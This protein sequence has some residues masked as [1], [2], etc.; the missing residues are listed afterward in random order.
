[1][2]ADQLLVA[3]QLATSRSQAQRLIANGLQWLKGAEWKTVTKNGDEIPPDAQVRLLDDAEARYVS[4]GGLKLEAALKQVGL[5]VTG[6]VCLDVGQSTGG[7]T[8][9]LLQQGAAM[10][11]GVDQRTQLSTQIAS[12]QTQ[13]QSAPQIKYVAVLADG[14]ADPSMLVTFDATNNKLLLQRVGGYQE[15]SDKS[16][17][18]WALPPSGGPR[19]LGVLG[20]DKLLRL[21]AGEGDVHA[22]P[23]LAITLEP[24]GGVPVGSGPT[25]PVLFKGALIQKML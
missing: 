18:L 11:V 13:L 20:T 23:T 21:T 6:L 22:V 12:L 10:V 8:D 24:K 14:K 19:S 4:R 5:N 25:G 15:A 17:Q 1:M 16:L 3:R 7:F 2:R 9:C